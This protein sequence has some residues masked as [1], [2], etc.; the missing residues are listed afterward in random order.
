[1]DRRGTDGHITFLFACSLCNVVSLIP[2]FHKPARVVVAQT[3]LIVC[4]LQHVQ[5]H[6]ERW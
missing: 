1:M 4:C 3:H 6:G 5:R 2:L